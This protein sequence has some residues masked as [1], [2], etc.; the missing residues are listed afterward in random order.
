MRLPQQ[1]NHIRLFQVYPVWIAFL[2]ETSFADADCVSESLFTQDLIDVPL[3][4]GHSAVL[5]TSDENYF[6]IGRAVEND[7][8][9]VVFSFEQLNCPP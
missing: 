2:D 3:D 6:K 4:P 7:D 9:M 1:A 8:H 5:K